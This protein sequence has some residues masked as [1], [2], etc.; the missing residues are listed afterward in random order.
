[1]Q[2]QATTPHPDPFHVNLQFLN[3]IS[4]SEVEIHV[5]TIR[6]GKQF[7]NLSV[8]LIQVVGILFKSRLH[9]DQTTDKCMNQFR[10]ISKPEQ[11]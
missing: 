8:D 7:S 1:M 3:F 4:V 10:V 2:S 11:A 5:I 6:V 9:H